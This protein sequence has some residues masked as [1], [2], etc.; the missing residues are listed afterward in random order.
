MKSNRLFI[1]YLSCLLL[2]PTIGACSSIALDKNNTAN[3]ATTASQL[4]SEQLKQLASK[5]TVKVLVD[6]NQGSGILIAKDGQ[7][8]TVVTN[9]HV[10]DRGQPY[11][12][13]T[14][15]GKIH[16][17]TLKQRDN[18]LARQDIA[19]LQFK[20][21]QNY[22]VATLGDSKTLSNEQAVFAAGFP[23]ES[24][25]LAFNSG[26][27]SAIAVKPLV[28]GY[29]IGFS[30]ETKQGMSGG[31]LLDEQGKLIGILGQ[32]A[33]AILNDSYTYQDGSRPNEQTI[34]QMRQSSF[35]IPV[36]ILASITPQ[37]TVVATN[38]KYTVIPATVDEIAQKVTLLITSRQN[39]NGSGVI[40]ARQ[41]QTY[42][43][44]TAAHVI[45]NPDQYEI[46]TPD[47]KKYQLDAAAAKK[48]EGIDLVLLPFTSSETYQIATLADYYIGLEDKP[49]VF[50][51]GFPGATSG[52]MNNPRRTLTAGTTFSQAVTM[53]AAQNT[54]SLAN[55]YEMVYSNLSEPGM[56]GGPVFDHLGRVI[57][58]NTAFEAG[59]EID[60]EGQT[61]EVNLGRGLG[62]PIR[63]FLGLS[64]KANL[65]SKLLKVETNAPPTLN[66]T[67][68][69]AIQENMLPEREPAQDAS[70]FE[71]LN[72]GN[73][74]WRLRKY[75][76]AIAAFDKAIQLKPDFYQA[77]YAKGTALDAQNK[78]LEAAAAYEQATKIQP[79]FYEAWRDRA[80]VLDYAKKSSE[81]LASID[82][83][84]QLQPQDFVLFFRRGQILNSL[85]RYKE[86]KEAFTQAI[87]LKPS[88]FAYT[89]RAL[90]NA[91]LRDYQAA[92]SDYSRAIQ[93]QPNDYFSYS[94]RG[95]VYA[96]LG[97][98]Q[99][100]LADLNK[101]L[102]M[103]PKSNQYKFTAYLGRATTHLAMGDAQAAIADYTA[104][105]DGKAPEN[106]ISQAYLGRATIYTQLQDFNKA[107]A[108]C[109]Q[110]LEIQPDNEVVYFNRGGFRAQAQD[111]QGALEDFNKAIDLQN[112]YADA[113][114]YRATVRA[115]LNDAPGMMADSKVALEL[116]T[117]KIA[118]EPKNVELYINRAITYIGIGDRQTALQ[119]VQKAEQLLQ[120]Q[121]ITSGVGYELVQKMKNVLQSL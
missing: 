32:S 61:V 87:S 57:G 92:I 90:S 60:R 86:A 44:L 95:S 3:L 104:I 101:A 78:Y 22:I 15:D 116:Y 93:L 94:G 75:P 26:K 52:T 109:T 113:Y 41:G 50:L 76:E 81:A 36:A 38:P 99:E 103:F 17:A 80:M 10:I 1:A 30:S 39:G 100:A 69:A 6:E 120:E 73:Q 62:I 74:L 31:A 71:W 42:Y 105:I 2:F 91:N 70:E 55:G 98:H 89:L 85:E 9:K 18:S 43:V 20:T 119:D 47:G 54:F 59:I 97:K 48:F 19:F 88:F 51:S 24:D 14:P 114:R 28:G 40:V 58:I 117:K 96:L 56:S 4:S 67:E 65:D 111:F 63:T 11:R 106:L 13:Q 82:K 46:V 108:D 110:L 33:T 64:S 79:S 7:T 16:Q 115:N 5:I 45:A 102:A 37:E 72:W 77:Y 29:Q 121:G 118:K 49:L 12:I 23:F 107:I 53:V 34:Q 25:R 68:V 84:L 66:A 8:Y 83:A 21:D 27:I 35:A 112:D